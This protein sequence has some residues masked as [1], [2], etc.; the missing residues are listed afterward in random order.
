LG[1]ILW[2]PELWACYRLHDSSISS[3]NRH[4][5]D[6][7]VF[8]AARLAPSHRIAATFRSFQR[9]LETALERGI[10]SPEEYRSLSREVF[11]GASRVRRYIQSWRAPYFTRIG[12][13]IGVLLDPGPYTGDSTRQRLMILANAFLPFLDGLY[14]RWV[15]IPRFPRRRES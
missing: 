10:L 15:R 1:K 7:A 3:T 11:E 4:A 6:L 14:H 2:V 9:D 13:A 5:E 8:T 12:S